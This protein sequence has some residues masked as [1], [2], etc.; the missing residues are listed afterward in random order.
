MD[1]GERP[2]RAGLNDA[3]HLIFEHDW[4]NDHVHRARFADGGGDPHVTR[5]NLIEHDGLLRLGDL[6]DQRLAEQHFRGCPSA[7]AQPV[8]GDQPQ[9]RLLVG[10]GLG[11]EE[12]AVLSPDQGNELVH[13]ELGN[14]GQVPLALHQASD[15]SQASLQP[16]LLPV[17]LG[18]LPQRPDHRVDVVLQFGDLAL[19][20]DGDR[21]GQVTGGDGAGHLGN[22]A[23]LPGQVGGQLVDVLG[24]PLPGPGHPLDLGLPAQAA[25]AAN[26]TGN[27]GDL[28]GEAGELVDHRVDG[29]LEFQ[30]LPARVHVDLLG[31]VALRDGGGD[32]RDVAHLAGQVVG[33]RVDVVGQVLPRPGHVRDRGLAFQDAFGADLPGDPGHLAGERG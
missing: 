7:E 10:L 32:L 6:A 1:L 11:Q 9:P 8:P 21:P 17:R 5:R 20:L 18:G 31:Q 15:L 26:L 4:H 14:D 24:Q 29:G 2:Q 28:G 13:D 27:A 16:A 12:R 25:F 3:E 33:H 23:D 19:R 22:R 30:D